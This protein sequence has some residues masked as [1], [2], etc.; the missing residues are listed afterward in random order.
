M[1]AGRFHRVTI[2]ARRG[3]RQRIERSASVRSSHDARNGTGTFAWHGV[4]FRASIV[5]TRR[6]VF[7]LLSLAVTGCDGLSIEETQGAIDAIRVCASTRTVVEGVDVSEF[8]PTV[9]WARV[10]GSGRRFAF[11]RVS[12]GARVVDTAFA[13]HW[14]GARAAGLL[15]GAY[16]FFRPAQDPDAQADLMIRSVGRL[17]PGDLPPVIDIET[18]DGQSSATIV[19]RARRWIER[20]RAGTGRD[21]IVY[22]AAGFWDPLQGT[23]ELGRQ[24]LWVANYTTSCPFLPE[25]WSRWTFWQFTDRGS[26]PGIAGPAD[27]NVFNGTVAELEALAGAGASADVGAISAG[28]PS[29]PVRWER[30]SDGAYAFSATAPEGVRRVEFRV[31]DVVIATAERGVDGVARGTYRFRFPGPARPLLVRGFD[32]SGAEVARALGMLDVVDDNALFVRPVGDQTYELG[33]ERAGSGLSSI[34]ASADGTALR[35][36]VTGA[37]RVTRG[38]LRYRFNTVGLRRLTVTRVSASGATLGV[39]RRDLVLR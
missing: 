9:D 32:A 21:P 30:A 4:C 1:V 6:T 27:V 35:D 26:V 39:D 23:A 5:T 25:D 24:K 17:G 10:R 15:R 28:A 13:S 12:D 7:F 33:Y 29:F 38:V 16:Q 18:A 36:A 19:A 20:V 37:T 22:A 14:R 11:I 8:Q 2:R 31:D 3:I 34:E